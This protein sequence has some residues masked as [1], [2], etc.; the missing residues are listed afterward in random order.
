M[1]CKTRVILLVLFLVCASVP[2]F[3]SLTGVLIVG[4]IQTSAPIDFILHPPDESN[5]GFTPWSAVSASEDLTVV[6]STNSSQVSLCD[7]LIQFSLSRS[8]VKVS[9]CQYQN[10]TRVD[11]REFIGTNATIK[12]IWL[13]V[14]EWDQLAGTSSRISKAVVLQQLRCRGG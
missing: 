9:V 6:R 10:K 3:L 12:G 7:Q 4:K 14:N 11:I 5:D 1:T 8:S 13:D 2:L